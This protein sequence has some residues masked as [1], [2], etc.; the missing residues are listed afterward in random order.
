MIAYLSGNLISKSFEYI[1]LE[2]SGIGYKVEIPLTTFYDLPELGTKISLH[3]FTLVREDSIRLF[4][5]NTNQERRLFELFLAISRVGPKLALNI[6]SGMEFEAL[7]NAINHQEISTLSSIPG[8]GKKTAERILFEI[9]GKADFIISDRS[10]QKASGISDR[11]D[12]VEEIA[13][14]LSNLGYKKSDSEKAVRRT[15]SK[16]SSSSDIQQLIKES[17][18]LLSRRKESE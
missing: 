10:D 13:S 4:G 8:V 7:V 16:F 1:I 11:E 2:I 12:S 14:I 18:K 15:M 6:L 17:L 9:K 3:I 5:F